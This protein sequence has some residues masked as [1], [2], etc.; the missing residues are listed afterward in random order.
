MGKNHR[1]MR[2][3]REKMGKNKGKMSKG[4]AVQSQEPV[5]LKIGVNSCENGQK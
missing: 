1:K 5:E 2:K 3:N 4:A